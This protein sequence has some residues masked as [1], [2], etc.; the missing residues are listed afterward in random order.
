MARP[1]D[2]A[3]PDLDGAILKTLTTLIYSASEFW[4]E[5]EKQ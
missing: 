4:F 3:F 5:A 1:A 2:E